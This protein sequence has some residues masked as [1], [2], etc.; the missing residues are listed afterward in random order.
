MTILI[1]NFAFVQQVPW[2][3]AQFE[4]R[5]LVISPA[6]NLGKCN[7]PVNY[8]DE[9]NREHDSRSGRSGTGSLWDAFDIVISYSRTRSRFEFCMGCIGYLYRGGSVTRL[10]WDCKGEPMD[11]TAETSSSKGGR[12]RKHFSTSVEDKTNSWLARSNSVE[13]FTEI[14]QTN[15]CAFSWNNSPAHFLVWPNDVVICLVRSANVEFWGPRISSSL[16]F[17]LLS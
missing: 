17:Y 10:F 4:G 6:Y 8:S 13:M 3:E 7:I 14:I 12:Q 9:S 15:R 2:R 11:H 1:R 5:R 16:V